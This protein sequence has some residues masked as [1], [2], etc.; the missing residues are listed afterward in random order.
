MKKKLLILSIAIMI[1]LASVAGFV[2]C[3]KKTDR[4]TVSIKDEQ[5]AL[6]FEPSKAAKYGLIFYVGTDIEPS[7]YSYLGYRLAEE[8]FLVYIPKT[9]NNMPYQYYEQNELAFEKYPNVQFFVGG[10]SNQGADAA[11]R[12][13]CENS[14]SVKGA[15][16]F[17]P[18]TVGYYQVFDKDGNPAT[19][20][21]G[22]LVYEDYSLANSSLPALYVQGDKDAVCESSQMEQAKS[23]MPQ[24][25]VYKTIENGNHTA[26]AEINET[27]D[28]PTM[29]QL[30]PNFVS[31]VNATTIEQKDNQ[32]TLAA[33]Y[34]L[35][36]IKANV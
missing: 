33:Y 21:D 2:A 28:L 25:C 30:F 14:A 19:D 4:I 1:L 13:I 20:K 22:N 27:T 7:K 23:R 35:D 18:I 31:D 36:F 8:G 17:S 15:I 5:N 24:N 10:H 9:K 34:V 12:R 3:D 32:R 26:F 6:V 29:F 11:L 16:F